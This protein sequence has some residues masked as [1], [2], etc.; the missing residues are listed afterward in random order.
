M[1]EDNTIELN[2]RRVLGG[3]VT[4]GAAAA[5]AG[6]GTFAFFNDSESSNN[7]TI[8]AGTLDLTGTTDG[9][10]SV[11]NLAPSESVSPPP[12]SATYD[13]SSSIDP[14]EGDVSF[15]LAEPSSEPTEPSNSTNQ[16]AS[17]FAG[18][19][20]VNTAELRR[21]G[22][23]ETDLTTSPQSVST[24]A[25]LGGVSV[26]AGFGSLSPGDNIDF[27]LEATFASGAGNQY[28]ADGV[29][30][31]VTFTAEQPGED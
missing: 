30:I 22:S 20:N 25:D 5:A 31:D 27:N 17:A 26:D 13:S 23:Q 29:Q 16:S 11:S 15:S 19:L 28:Q 8:T 4:I 9:E 7:N 21:N 1:S 3:V 12:V 2:R 10:I 6:A 18:Q 14:A 24:V